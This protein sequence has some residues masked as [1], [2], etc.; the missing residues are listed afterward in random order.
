ML[1]RTEI[2]KIGSIELPFRRSV[3]VSLVVPQNEHQT[4]RK[5]KIGK[6]GK[7]ATRKNKKRTRY[8]IRLKYET[9]RIVK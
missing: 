3:I 5:P 9:E 7:G 6:R 8:G 4:R 2:D 1:A